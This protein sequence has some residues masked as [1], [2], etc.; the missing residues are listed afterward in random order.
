MFIGLWDCGCD[1]QKLFRLALLIGLIVFVHCF[2][3]TFS[4]KRWRKIVHAQNVPKISF[5]KLLSYFIK[6]GNPSLSALNQVRMDNVWALH[7]E[8][9]L[10]VSSRQ[11]CKIKS[12]F[13]II[14]YLQK[15]QNNAKMNEQQICQ[16]SQRRKILVTY[17]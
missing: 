1:K 11:I 2:Q 5:F 13:V 9:A 7:L 10:L 3:L 14:V 4:K 8:L 6:L 17:Y 12:S 16:L 15:N